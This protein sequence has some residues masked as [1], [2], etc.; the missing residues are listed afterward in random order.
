MH[1]AKAFMLQNS[2]FQIWLHNRI[3]WETEKETKRMPSLKT[4]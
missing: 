4:N 2:G 3:V 1:P